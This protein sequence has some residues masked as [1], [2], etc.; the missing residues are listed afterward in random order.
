MKRLSAAFA[1]MMLIAPAA[2]ASPAEFFLQYSPSLSLGVSTMGA[3]GSLEFHRPY[4]LF[5]V[6]AGVNIFHFNINFTTNGAR[7]QAQAHFQN[8][9]IF[10]DYYPWHR[11]FHITAGVVFN[12][13]SADYS[14]S[15]E[16]TG[17]LLGFITST[18]Y[19][20]AVGNV[21]G[22]IS[23]NPV[24]PYLGIGWTY[25]VSKHWHLN[26]DIGAMYQG[27]GRITLTPTDLIASNPQM[28]AGMIANAQ[29]ADRMINKMSF[30][31]IIGFQFGYEF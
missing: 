9:T 24:A 21:H 15:P 31:P 17:A 2:K 30:Y 22:P 26:A 28:R 12:Q 19:T 25:N 6:R 20:G 3:G 10:A 8:E 14:S 16:I 29:Q 18:H 23:F 1:A 11:H 5:G 7:S 4:S 13:N 27:N